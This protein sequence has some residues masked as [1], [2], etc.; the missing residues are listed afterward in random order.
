MTYNKSWLATATLLCVAVTGCAT[1]S[2]SSSTA[3]SKSTSAQGTL[4]KKVIVPGSVID[5][6]YWNITV[7]TDMNK[8]GKPDQIKIPTISSVQ[9]PD[10]FYVNDEGSVVFATPNKATTTANSSNTRSE[11]RQ[12]IRGSNQKIK[13]HD[14]LNNF[15]VL[16]NPKSDKFGSIGGKLD[17][18]LSVNHV[19]VNAGH[20]EKFPAYSAV[21]GQ[22][23]G[24]KEKNP[25]AGSGYGNEPIKIYYKK[26]PNHETGSV[27]WTYERNLAKADPERKD[28]AFPVWGYTWENPANPGD[29]GI[30]LNENFSYTINVHDNIMHLTF[31]NAKQ[32][33]VNYSI[34]LSKNVDDK[35]N[36][37]GYAKE[38][39]Y[40]KAGIYNQCSTSDKE[41]FW[42][43][44]CPGTGIWSTD[45]ANGDYAQAT[46]SKVEL[47]PSVAP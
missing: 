17:A 42:Y 28:V 13:T 33:T 37:N 38:Q 22:I 1:D 43:A 30:A 32:G 25:P 6:S 12:M 10:Y 24:V 19:A 18:T 11:L 44:A 31:Q 14:Y 15:A 20:P 39:M 34:D 29:K 5:L 26:W 3:T 46:F 16:A 27:F 35:D 7:P 41:G 47:S 9:H 4:A 8:D 40:F 2:S 45:K 36:P 23:H 21:V